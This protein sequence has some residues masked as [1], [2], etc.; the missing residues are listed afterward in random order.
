[1]RI[2]FV[3]GNGF[4][5]NLGLQTNY[6]DF[7]KEYK[8]IQ[9]GDSEVIKWFKKDVLK[10]EKLWSSAE[11]AFGLCT[12]EFAKGNLT[13]EAFCECHEDFCAKLAT[14]LQREEEKFLSK[15][16]ASKILDGFSRGICN[17]I[18]GFR[19]DTRNQITQDLNTF[20]GGIIY[21]F[22]SFNYTRTIDKCVDVVHKKEDILGFRSHRNTNYKN[23]IG[24]VLHVHGYVD[25]DMVLG[26]NDIA[27]IADKS[28]FKGYGEE[29]INQIIKNQCNNMNEYNMDNKVHETLKSSDVIYIYGMSIGSTDALWWQRVC[30]LMKEKQNLHVII[31]KYDAPQDV[32]IR[33][34]LVTFSKEKSKEFLS[35]GELNETE[36]L[37]LMKRV[38]IDNSNLFKLLSN[39]VNM[40]EIPNE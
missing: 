4:D 32:L 22:I 2:T 9:E 35:F 31:H 36:I 7:L 39:C 21:D 20:A 28:I 14:Y 26:V 6:S 15:M 24:K 3:V 1:M 12:K 13:A 27:Q 16:P 18:N 40:Q 34:K 17:W 30:K 38:H 19:D 11:I 23:K 25:M 10:D 29:Y 8:E 33:R 37:E 5:L